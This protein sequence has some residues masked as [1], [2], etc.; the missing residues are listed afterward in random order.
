MLGY[1]LNLVETNMYLA[2]QE[3]LSG[4]TQEPIDPTEVPVN[5]N[6]SGHSATIVALGPLNAIGMVTHVVVENG[7]MGGANGSAIMEAAGAHYGVE[8]MAYTPPN[9]YELFIPD[10]VPPV[11]LPLNGSVIITFN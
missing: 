8:S 9:Q 2:L 3:E 6:N 1:P 10:G 4:M 7:T 5:P 11:A